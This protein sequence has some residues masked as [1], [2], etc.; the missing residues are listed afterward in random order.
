[1][2]DRNLVGVRLSDELRRVTG[3]AEAE[4]EAGG[5]VDLGVTCR[6]Q[7]EDDDDLHEHHR[8]RDVRQ[9]QNAGERGFRGGLSVTQGGEWKQRGDQEDRAKVEDRDA[10][11]N[12][13]DGRG[14]RGGGVLGLGGGD[15]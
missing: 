4:Q 5:R 13:A 6:E 10:P 7:G 8:T 15:G 1:D 3:A 12:S 2:L 11:D 14:D 9:L